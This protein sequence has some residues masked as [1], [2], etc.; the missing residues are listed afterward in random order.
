MED[1]LLP[2]ND[3]SRA[4]F[5]FLSSSRGPIFSYSFNTNEVRLKSVSIDDIYNDI[6][7][8]L[9]KNINSTNLEYLIPSHHE[10]LISEKDDLTYS[11]FIKNNCCFFELS[12][13]SDAENIK[14][15]IAEIDKALCWFDSA[16]FDGAVGDFFALKILDG[17]CFVK[18]VLNLVDEPNLTDH[19][20]IKNELLEKLLDYD[21]VILDSGYTFNLFKKVWFLNSTSLPIYVQDDLTK[22]NYLDILKKILSSID[23]YKIESVTGRANIS[24]LKKA[25]KI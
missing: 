8:E 5:D 11:C 7:A 23:Q 15:H 22:D 3:D 19:H 17:E 4:F 25:K 14:K 20:L 2:K 6:K 1:Y 16:I 18:S 10:M 21:V 13:S 9:D 24:R 12:K